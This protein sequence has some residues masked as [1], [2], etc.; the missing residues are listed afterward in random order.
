MELCRF[1]HRTLPP[2]WLKFSELVAVRLFIIG[3][4][5]GCAKQA[6]A[7]SIA[8]TGPCD[9]IVDDVSVHCAAFAN[10][11]YLD[12]VAI[13]ERLECCLHGVDVS[14]HELR[15]GF[16]GDDDIGRSWFQKT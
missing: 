3:K 7:Y 12:P 11:T 1:F 14:P 10:L 15:H 5:Y 9:P 13:P 2:C 6:V 8:L 16:L 4:N